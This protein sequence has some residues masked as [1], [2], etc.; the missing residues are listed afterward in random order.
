LKSRNTLN[1]TDRLIKKI[2]S[3]LF[4]LLLTLLSIFI[5]QSQDNSFPYWIYYLVIIIYLAIFFY[6]FLKD[7]WFQSLCRLVN[8][9]ALITFV[10]YQKDLFLIPNYVLVVLPVVNA[11]NHSG[12]KSSLL[13]PILIVVIGFLSGWEIN[14]DLIIPIMI[15]G[16]INVF[17]HYRSQVLDAKND[18]VNLIEQF[19]TSEYEFRKFHNVYD[20]ILDHIK[21]IKY[22]KNMFS[23]DVLVCFLVKNNRLLLLNS[24]K[25]IRYFE[26]DKEQELIEELE[27]RGTCD[28]FS[29]K[30]MENSFH[31]NLFVMSKDEEMT[32][33]F[34][35]ILHDD[36]TSPIGRSL[37]R[38]FF[39]PI[40]HHLFKIIKHH[41]KIRSSLAKQQS[42]IRKQQQYVLK[43]MNA[44][45]YVR[46]KLTPIKTYLNLDE[47]EKAVIETN[48][49]IIKSTFYNKKENALKQSKNQLD[50][51]VQRADFIL[52]KSDN[53]FIIQNTSQHKINTLFSLIR[54][55]WM[56]F[57]DDQN[58]KMDFQETFP[59]VHVYYNAEVIE[60]V[61]AD[62]M[63]NMNK[64]GTEPELTILEL[65][66]DITF[67]FKNRIST[68]KVKD[69]TY[70]KRIAKSYNSD[71]SWEINKRTTHGLTLIKSYL[72]Q[73]SIHSEIVLENSYFI[74]KMRF[75]KHFHV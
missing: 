21:S 16:L 44:M 25:F 19:F 65:D 6:F 48:D 8:D 38:Y 46:N 49:E 70:F 60:I 67:F 35:I 69:I 47:I 23:I 20:L 66:T 29:I 32:L 2:F 55:N 75:A 34:S 26:I 18:L 1:A 62:V 22:M 52:E 39:K 57:F 13:Y 3:I 10:L 15:L 31:D 28:D 42:R 63:S 71:E 36:S 40:S 11:P 59:D 51:I 74:F 64:Y 14:W 12:R 27:A 17:R 58:F 54:F 61:L 5:I 56:S 33:V 37:L 68:N 41:T 53:P 9:Y 43:S 4:R 24:S 45:H 50:N 30:L 72:N 7:S 73:M